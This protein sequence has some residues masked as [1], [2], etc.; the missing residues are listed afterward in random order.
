MDIVSE[1]TSLSEE[2]LISYDEQVSDEERSAAAPSLAERIS[3][4]KVYLLADST[5]VRSSKRKRGE[6]DE[7][8]SGA[9]EEEADIATDNGTQGLTYSYSC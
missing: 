6:E 9:D 7:V 3:R 8:T 5:A 2:T 4:N 1:G